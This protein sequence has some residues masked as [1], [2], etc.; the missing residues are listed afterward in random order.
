MQSK[1]G[2]WYGLQMVLEWIVESDLGDREAM[3]LGTFP[4]IFHAIN[5]CVMENL[6][7][8][9]SGSQAAIKGLNSNEVDS[10]LVWHCLQLL[11]EL[12]I[13]K[14]VR[15]CW[16]PRHEEIEGNAKADEFTKSDL[17]LALVFLRSQL[18]AFLTVPQTGL[19]EWVQKRTL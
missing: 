3:S 1:Y 9:F 17:R 2:S 14:R 7:I 19:W 11:N 15:L 6:M 10:R 8:S 13:T 16:A 5:A 4:T 12:A 18:L